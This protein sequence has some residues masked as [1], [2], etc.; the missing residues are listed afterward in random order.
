MIW[1]NVINWQVS[2]HDLWYYDN[3]ILFMWYNE[4]Y[5]AF[6]KKKIENCPFGTSDTDKR[7][8]FT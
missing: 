1:K 2:K 5:V 7:H 6:E 3:F 4:C 8:V